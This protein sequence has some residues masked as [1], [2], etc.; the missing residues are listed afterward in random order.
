MGLENGEGCCDGM[1][2]TLMNSPAAGV[3]CIRPTKE[4]ASQ[5][6]CIDGVNDL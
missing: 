4:Q 3:R 2:I 1:A 5:N 6:S